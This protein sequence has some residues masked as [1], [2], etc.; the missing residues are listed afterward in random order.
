MGLDAVASTR[1]IDVLSPAHSANMMPE[2][3]EA[4]H[5]SHASLGMLSSDLEFMHGDN[6]GLQLPCVIQTLPMP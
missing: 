1:D 3:P 2:I 4:S 6:D 5:G